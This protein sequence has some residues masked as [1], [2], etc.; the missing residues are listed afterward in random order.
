MPLLVE[1]SLVS[2]GRHLLKASYR[3]ADVGDDYS[4]TILLRSLNESAMT[5]AW[6]MIDSELAAL[7]MRRDEVQYQAQ[8][9]PIVRRR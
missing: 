9:A 5:F 7:V 8:S 3:S 1:L 2:R 4:A 6:L